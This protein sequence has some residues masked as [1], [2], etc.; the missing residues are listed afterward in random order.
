MNSLA[1]SKEKMQVHT[2][3]FVENEI[4]LCVFVFRTYK[5]VL[6]ST[7]PAFCM[8][9]RTYIHPIAIGPLD[10]R[11]VLLMGCE[12]VSPPVDS[13]LKCFFC[14]LIKTFWRT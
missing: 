6:V 10:I 4:L 3:G 5:R 11:S 2:G 13:T 12:V 1:V 14:V 8:P 9:I 7:S